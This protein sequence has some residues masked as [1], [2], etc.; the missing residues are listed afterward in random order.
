MVDLKSEKILTCLL[1]IIVGYYIAK[2]FSRSCNGFS[3]GVPFNIDDEVKYIGPNHY[4]IMSNGEIIDNPPPGLT[5]GEYITPET[6]GRVLG[7][8]PLSIFGTT[9]IVRFYA[10]IG[11]EL[12]ILEDELELYQNIT[13][14]PLPDICASRSQP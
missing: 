4:F 3:I 10:G 14:I 5:M 7:L 11:G 6:R 9:Y 8:G 2:M 12:T 13:P 1:L